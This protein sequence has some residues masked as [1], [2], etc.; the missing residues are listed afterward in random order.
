MKRQLAQMQNQEQNHQKAADILSD[1]MTK[2]LI[3]Q[4]G[5]GNI[6]VPSASKKR[7][8]GA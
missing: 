8:N 5:S 1:L 2:G 3:T 7:P 4:D 6:D